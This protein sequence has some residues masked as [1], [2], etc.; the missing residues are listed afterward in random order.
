MASHIYSGSFAIFTELFH[1]FSLKVKFCSKHCAFVWNSRLLALQTCSLAEVLLMAEEPC[2]ESKP[3]SLS[4]WQWFPKHQ[5]RVL[6]LQVTLWV[7]IVYSL[8]SK[9]EIF[10]IKKTKIFQEILMWFSKW[11]RKGYTHIF[12]RTGFFLPV[13][14]KRWFI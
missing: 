2:Q 10:K 1:T 11:K 14:F 3:A 12:L 7:V 5:S 4:F 6:T 9:P 13:Y 8:T